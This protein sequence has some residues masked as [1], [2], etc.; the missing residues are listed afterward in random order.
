MADN[1]ITVSAVDRTKVQIE[2]DFQGDDD[3]VFRKKS[4]PSFYDREKAIMALSVGDEYKY[5]PLS[6]EDLLFFWNTEVIGN[7]GVLTVLANV[8]FAFSLFVLTFWGSKDSSAAL[9]LIAGSSISFFVLTPYMVSLTDWRNYM[10]EE[11]EALLHSSKAMNKFLKTMLTIT[12]MV[13]ISFL[14]Y[15]VCQLTIENL[16]GWDFWIAMLFDNAS[17]QFP[18]ICFGLYTQ[19]SH[20]LVEIFSGMPF[21]FMIFFSTTYSPGAGLPVIKELRYLFT[22]YYMFCMTPYVDMMME[23][24]PED[25]QMNL[26]LLV[27]SGCLC[28]VLFTTFMAVAHCARAHQ[29]RKRALSMM[30]LKEDE[31]FIQLSQHFY[32]SKSSRDS[33]TTFDMTS[34]HT[35]KHCDTA[36]TDLI[37]YGS[38]DSDVDSVEPDFQPQFIEI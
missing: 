15:C 3:Y 21:L 37:N 33:T 20:Q 29:R 18:F 22:R 6:K 38:E 24:C 1:I 13:M 31:D 16:K 27:F 12:M 7:G 34:N 10:S 35:L 9:V 28:V 4:T 5:A 23:D 17:V 11:A 14:Q 8:I 2:G 32:R 36:K 30:A 26:M 19:L 25:P